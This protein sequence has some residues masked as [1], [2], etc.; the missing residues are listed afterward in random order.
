MSSLL[1]NTQQ[2][3][4]SSDA[5]GGATARALQAVHVHYTAALE[6]T[7]QSFIPNAA[8]ALVSLEETAAGETALPWLSA[9]WRLT[10]ASPSVTLGAMAC[11]AP[12]ACALVDHVLGNDGNAGEPRALSAI[13]AHLLQPLVAPL[14]AG[15]ADTWKRHARLDLHPCDDGAL[16]VDAPLFLAEYEVSA[17]QGGGNFF[18]ILPLPAWEPVLNDFV[19]EAKQPAEINTSLLET[20]GLCTLCARVVLGSTR[21]A[22]RDLLALRPDDIICLEQE[23]SAPVQIRIGNQPKLQGYVQIENGQYTVTIERIHPGKAAV[24]GSE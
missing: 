17:Q 24:D 5:R 3:L 4:S 21:V 15:Y 9:S 13:E 7:V 2:R 23:P 1:P 6:R 20:L 18:V 19:R 16:P 11:S 22:V 12:L 8:V 14:L 10:F